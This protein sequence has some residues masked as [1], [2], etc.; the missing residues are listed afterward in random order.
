MICPEC[1]A[2][3]AKLSLSEAVVLEEIARNDGSLSYPKMAKAL[4]MTLPSVKGAIHRAYKKIGVR[5]RF[6]V[7]RYWRCELFQVGL[8]ELGIL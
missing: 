2:R 4:S 7:V 8:K 5:T 1:G 3:I 6:E